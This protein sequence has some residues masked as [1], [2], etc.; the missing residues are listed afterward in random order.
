MEK[1]VNHQ[2]LWLAVGVALGVS[3]GT[4]TGQIG[5]GIAFGA[6]LGVVIG[7]V[8]SRRTGADS[9]EM[10]I[11]HVRELHKPGDWQEVLQRSQDDFA[12]DE[13]RI[14]EY[15]KEILSYQE[16]SKTQ[17]FAALECDF[18]PGMTQPFDHYRN[19][20]NM[21]YLIGGHS[22]PRRCG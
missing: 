19:D 5:L 7:S 1:K 8:I 4:A 16:N 17:L 6:A 12:I 15:V 2:A 22:F 9:H 14:P 3:L 18:I 13:A 10:L 20:Y 21:D 11:E